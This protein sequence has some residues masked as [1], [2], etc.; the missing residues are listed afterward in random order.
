MSTGDLDEPLLLPHKDGS[1]FIPDQ[2]GMECGD[3]LAVWAEALAS[4]TDLAMEDLQSRAVRPAAVIEI[5]DEDGEPV[6]H[7]ASTRVF[8]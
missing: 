5:E 3:M 1:T 2:E 4:A 8:N 7:L 6:S